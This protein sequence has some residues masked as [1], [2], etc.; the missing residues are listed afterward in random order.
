TPT[1][2]KDA[3][4]G[5]DTQAAE[6]GSDDGTKDGNDGPATEPSPETV[7][8]EAAVEKHGAEFL[9]GIAR[10]EPRAFLTGEQG[11]IVAEKIRSIASPTLAENLKAAKNNASQIKT[12]AAEK[13]LKP[14][15][16]SAAAIAKMG[17]GRGDIV[18]T[19]RS[20]AEVL[21]VL[22]TQIGDE[23]GD[24][25]LL[26]LAAY[27]QGA[28]GDT[29]K[30]R[31]MLQGLTGKYQV[32]LRTIRSIWFLKKNDLITDQQYEL[33]LR[34]LAVGTVMQNPK[35]FNVNAEPVVF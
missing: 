9:R 1:P 13:N 21:A 30:M 29:M 18:Q 28:A 11:R 35:A 26:T 8:P 32:S 16:L 22:R 19:A 15:T 34:F 25:V 10:N 24:D 7:T 6:D 17:G 33:A 12:I 27:D 5:D 20:V 14:Q 4:A 31:N 3:D 23:F 2:K